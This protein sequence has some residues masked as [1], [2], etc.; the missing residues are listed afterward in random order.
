MGQFCGLTVLEKC[1]QRG[2][3]GVN[4]PENRADVLDG[5]PLNSGEKTITTTPDL[6]YYNAAARSATLSPT[7][8][9][10]SLPPLLS[11]SLLLGSQQGEQG[12]MHL[13]FQTVRTTTIEIVE[14]VEWHGI[15]HLGLKLFS[16]GMEIKFGSNYGG[17][18]WLNFSKMPKRGKS[19]TSYYHY[20]S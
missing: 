9:R 3:G 15:Q 14:R 1:G 20:L 12:K 17:A 6:D 2:S 13:S 18:C 8:R 7:D 5:S 11:S 4:N 10:R 19:V 16:T